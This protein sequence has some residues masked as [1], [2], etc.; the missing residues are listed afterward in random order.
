MPRIFRLVGLCN[1]K[2]GEHHLY[3]T[4]IERENYSAPDIVQFYR[5]RWGV[6][7]VFEELK[8]WFG[9]DEV[10]T[11][12]PSIIDPLIIMTAIP[13]IMNRVIVDEL[14]SLEARQRK[15]EAIADADS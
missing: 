11:T 3:L 1:E 14:R 15:A 12:D 13:L 8:S 5:T 4:S 7:L 10:N 9:L 2:T 6:E